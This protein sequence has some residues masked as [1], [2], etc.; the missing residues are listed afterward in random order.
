[1]TV[2]VA[3]TSCKCDCVRGGVLEFTPITLSQS[4]TICFPCH[5]LSFVSELLCALDKS[6]NTLVLA[7]AC[8]ETH[9][10]F[11]HVHNRKEIFLTFE[12]Q[13][14]QKKTPRKTRVSKYTSLEKPW[15]QKNICR[16]WSQKAP[17]T[18]G[19]EKLVSRFGCLRVV[20]MQV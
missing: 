7:Q 19:S 15:S 6:S 16:N 17:K 14:Y 8:R 3:D 11:A 20:C 4:C 2:P 1:M 5:S 9:S 12:N 10:A 13:K 18:V